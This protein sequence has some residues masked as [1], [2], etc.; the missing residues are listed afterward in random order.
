MR[1][2]TRDIYWIGANDK[3][4]ERFENYIP[5]PNGVTYNSYLIKGEKT[6][7]IDAV[8]I[9]L[10]IDLMQKLRDELEGRNLDYVVV[11]HMEPDHSGALEALLKFYPNVKI[12]GNSKTFGMIEAFFPEVD[13]DIFYE[14]KEGDTLDLGGYKLSFAMI[15]M[16]HWPETMVAYEETEK[17][18]FSTDA[19]GGFG[20]LEGGIFDDELDF[21]EYEVDMR[22]YYSNIV[23]K[24]GMQVEKAIEK[25]KKLDVKCICPAHGIIWRKNPNLV[26]DKYLGWAKFVPEK[27][28]VIIAYASMY[29][30]TGKMAEYIAGKIKE[31][32]IEDVKTY[33]VSKTDQT[34]IISEI[35]KYKGLVLGCCAH[36]N[37]LYPK[38]VPILHKLKN[39]GLKNRYLG[40]FGNMMWSGGGVR[41]LE[42]F[43]SHMKGIEVVADSVEAKGKPKEKDIQGLDMIAKNIAEKL[44]SER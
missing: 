3:K 23:G 39:Y 35:W 1:N 32:G 29:G 13:Q 14:V 26:V 19:F 37:E 15:P 11:T 10:G 8:E 28:G 7:L 6:C 5:L 21:S 24:Y 27:E 9:D 31:Y 4:S 44:I 34:F 18:L 12:V 41:G 30:T 25:V 20:T 22:R 33:D 16:V 38:M 17:I 2:I 42:E 36:N 43:A 40:I